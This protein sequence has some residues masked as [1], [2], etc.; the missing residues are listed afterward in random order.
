MAKDKDKKNG[1][2]KDRP[3]VPVNTAIDA[4]IASGY[5]SSAAAVSEIID[6]SIEAHAKNI[7]IIVFDKLNDRGIKK[8]TKIAIVDDGTGMDNEVLAT[9]LQFGNGSKLNS[10]KGLGRFGIGL[11]NSSVSQCNIVDV[12]SWQKEKTLHTYLSVPEYRASKNQNANDVLEKELP[13]D[14]KKEI[15]NQGNSGTAVIWSDCERIDVAKADTLYRRISRDISRV[16]RYFLYKGNKKYKTINITYKVVGID[17][18]KE[19][20]PNDPLYLMEES[21]TNDYE[22]KAVMSLRTKNNEPREGKIE[23]KVIDPITKKQKIENVTFRFSSIKSEI[24]TKERD[25]TSD[26]MT[27]IKRNTGISFVR[28]GREIDFGTFD[29]FDPSQATERWWG[30][31]IVFEPIL[32]EVFG[33]SNNK[34]GVKN[35]NALNKNQKKDLGLTDEEISDSPKLYLR[36]EITKRFEKFKGDYKERLSLTTKGSRDKGNRSKTIFDKVV[37]GRKIITNSK[38]IGSNKT[39]G[40]KTIDWRKIIEEKA[41]AAGQNLTQKEIDNIINA[42]KSLEVSVQEGS[43]EGNQFFTIEVVGSTAVV[44]IN[45]NHP[46][47]EMM[48]QPLQEADDKKNAEILDLLLMSW[49][50]LEDELIVTDIEP[51]AFAKIRDRWG[52]H[53]TDTLKQL[54]KIS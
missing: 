1:F 42:N 14:V 20:K 27:H 19:F 17:E 43:W 40:Q 49:T 53:L 25:R 6:N 34:Q 5:R 4:F 36:Q 45:V 32:D 28:A 31:E 24:F 41:K 54:G 21:T 11:P 52:Q 23:L 51:D 10:R 33:V 8:I 37:K 29:Y 12:Y 48:Y 9:S 30:C 3:L 26:F 15:N 50:R 18:I 47:Y 16:Y 35:M 7:E 46:F 13:K 44:K 2:N 39:D 22:N 38:I